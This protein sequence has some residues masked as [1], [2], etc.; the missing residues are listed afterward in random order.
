MMMMMRWKI[1]L[2]LDEGTQLLIDFNF[3]FNCYEFTQP[4]ASPSPSLSTTTTCEALQI[5]VCGVTTEGCIA[6]IFTGVTYVRH[7]LVVGPRTQ[8]KFDV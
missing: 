1:M 8:G 7:S 3:C 2:M 6:M 4:S 5:S